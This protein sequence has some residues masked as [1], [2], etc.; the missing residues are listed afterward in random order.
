MTESDEF[1]A[2]K[3]GVPVFAF[4]VKIQT[5]DG[6][7]WGKEKPK[8][9]AVAL[10]AALLAELEGDISAYLCDSSAEALGVREGDVVV[11]RVP[12]KYKEGDVIAVKAGR[13]AGVKRMRKEKGAL[14]LEPDIAKVGTNELMSR[15][16][17]K[18]LMIIRNYK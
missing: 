11:V 18:A 12:E 1:I 7:E 17:G 6:G 8:I 9:S 16:L 3:G 13:F 5:A 10:P 2:S 15:R 14:I 4:E